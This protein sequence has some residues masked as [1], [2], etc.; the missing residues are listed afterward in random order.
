MNKNVKG[1]GP[2]R[3]LIKRRSERKNFEKNESL[4]GNLPSIKNRAKLTHFLAQALD[5]QTLQWIAGVVFGI[6]IVAEAQ[7]RSNDNP[8]NNQGDPAASDSKVGL[9]PNLEL[10]EAELTQEDGVG[11]DPTGLIG[12]Q[13]LDGWQFNLGPSIRALLA[14]IGT[15][16][17]SDATSSL[18]NLKYFFKYYFAENKIPQHNARDIEAGA[19]PK[20]TYQDAISIAVENAAIEFARGGFGSSAD[21]RITDVNE[22]YPNIFSD[23]SKM[24][25]KDIPLQFSNEGSNGSDITAELR[26]IDYASLAGVKDDESWGNRLAYLPGVGVGGAGGGGGGGSGSSVAVASGGG[27]G[28]SVAVASGGLGGSGGLVDGYVT[29]ATL[30]L[31]KYDKASASWKDVT[32]ADGTSVVTITDSQGAFSFNLTDKNLVDSLNGIQTRILAEAG[33]YDAFTG[34]QVGQ[35]ISEFALAKTTANQT[36]FGGT[37]QTTPLTMLLNLSGVNEEQFKTTIGISG[38]SNLASFDPIGEIIHQDAISKIFDGNGTLGESV[39]KVQQ[40]LYT[41]QQAL[42]AFV[43]GDGEVGEEA[44]TSATKAIANV[45]TKNLASGGSVLSLSDIT[46]ASV[47]SLLVGSISDPT[48]RSQAVAFAESVEKAINSTNTKIVAGYSGLA[49]ALRD[50]TS[51]ESQNLLSNA[52]AAASLSQFE[53]INALKTSSLSNFSAVDFYNSNFDRLIAKAADAFS[54]LAANVASSQ[55]LGNT[56]STPVLSVAQALV[57]TGA[58]NTQIKDIASAFNQISLAKIL[59]LNAN[60]VTLLGASSS[61]DIALDGNGLLTYGASGAVNLANLQSGTFNSDYTVTLKVTDADLL[62]VV[63]YA[64]AL[65]NAGIDA[66][67]PVSGTIQL[68]ASDAITLIKEGFSFSSGTFQV[69]PTKSIDF[70]TAKIIVVDGG[71]K[72][73]PGTPIDTRGQELSANEALAFI[74]AGASF[75]YPP[76][77]AIHASDLN[78]NVSVVIGKL[79]DFANLKLQYVFAPNESTAGSGVEFSAGALTLSG[80]SLTLAQAQALVNGAVA[81]GLVFNAVNVNLDVGDLTSASQWAKPLLQAGIHSYSLGTNTTVDLPQVNQLLNQDSSLTLVAKLD[82]KTPINATEAAYYAGRGLT[83]P[84]SVKFDLDYVKSYVLDNQNTFASSIT[85]NEAF[86]SS[87]LSAADFLALVNA[88]VKFGNIY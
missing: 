83:P 88:G 72:L 21:L 51:V 3:S 87:T 78:G 47:E 84:A 77:V 22:L 16:P 31:Q 6:A 41:L 24:L 71:L 43:A 52:R 25:I 35:F 68:S 53:L 15:Q 37:Q 44:L 55:N 82:S 9:P 70:A 32:N 54:E 50:P 42:A 73:P 38:V 40:G 34:Q 1:L 5:P 7:A 2:Q 79:L 28:P 19:N 81:G 13:S 4:P 58:A 30:H 66:L 64:K 11:K 74:K 65:S 46:N 49:D 67:K 69:L 56:G 45:F 27:S 36:S 20:S 29:G 33:G 75:L 14:E 86:S 62:N 12:T 80:I 8:A 48:L 59:A 18:E 63:R 23:S 57:Y 60:S 10:A 39:F 17:I 26:K 76:A 61:V 85:I